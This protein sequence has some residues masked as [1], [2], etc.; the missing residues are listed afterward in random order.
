MKQTIKTTMVLLLITLM[1]TSL[2]FA[3]NAGTITGISKDGNGDYYLNRNEIYE[4]ADMFLNAR[5]MTNKEKGYYQEISDEFIDSNLD[6]LVT[7]YRLSDKYLQIENDL[8]TLAIRHIDN[9]LN[10]ELLKQDINLFIEVEGE[11]FDEE[12]LQELL[13]QTSQLN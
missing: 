10:I 9:P 2:V 6:Y 4:E 3:E 5:I 13:T 11:N 8:H 12:Q 7:Y 1:M